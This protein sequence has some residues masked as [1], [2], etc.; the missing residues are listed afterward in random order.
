MIPSV[1]NNNTH[2]WYQPIK[3]LLWLIREYL[4]SFKN[5]IIQMN[6]LYSII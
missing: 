1:D 4:Y 3:L 6:K 5:K 2:G